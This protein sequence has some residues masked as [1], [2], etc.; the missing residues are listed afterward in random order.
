[1]L[2]DSRK[3]ETLPVT[4]SDPSD[5]ITLGCNQTVLSM[6]CDLELFNYNQKSIIN[7]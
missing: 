1:M 4:D 7:S 5:F 6:V 3:P 2:N